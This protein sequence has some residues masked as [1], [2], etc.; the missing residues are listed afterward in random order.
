M[1]STQYTDAYRAHTAR[2]LATLERD[3][4]L[5]TAIGGEFIAVGQL[6]FHLL[7]HYGLHDT[8]HVIDVGCGSGRLAA[9]LAP[10]A[11][12][13]Y[14]GL[15]VVPDLLEL[16]R[17]LSSR[18]DWSFVC[19]PGTGIDAPDA[20][21]DFVCFFSVFTHL[22]HEDS[23]R[24]LAEA[25]RVLKPGGH[26]IFSFLEFCVPCHWFV[27]ADTVRQTASGQHLNQFMD[28]DAI[29]AWADHLG[30]EIVAIHPG[31][32]GHIPIPERI[33]WENGTVMEKLGN[34]GQSVAVLRKPR[35]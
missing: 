3:E 10:L 9:Q 2:L 12:L 6:Q 28:R 22:L 26:V 29:R 34:M 14:L 23:Y 35:S 7:R 19:S 8:H 15:D 27:F 24:Y 30:F 11:G 16:A 17:R 21:A 33:I 20:S 1:S 25:L 32:H 13:H 18:D 5:K 4:A 31:D